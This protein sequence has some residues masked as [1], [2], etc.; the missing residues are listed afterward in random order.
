M[1]MPAPTSDASPS[2][3]I[4][5]SDSDSR[6]TFG[7]RNCFQRELRRRVEEF[8][9]DAGRPQR[10]CPQLY[11]KSALIL[12]AFAVSYG[13]LVFLAT[14]WWQAIPFALLLG[15]STTAIGFNIQHDAGHQAYSSRPWVNKL[16]SMTLDLIGGSSYVW[17][18]KH[19][20]YHHTYVNITGHDTDIDLGIVG[21]L[22]PHQKRH[23]FHRWQ[24][25]YLWPAYGLLA[26]KWHFFTD[27]H[28]VVTGRIGRHRMP[29]PKGWDLA[30]FLGGK[31]TF[32]G[33]AFVI[34]LLFHP[35][36]IVLLVY[37]L[38]VVILGAV[39]SVV[40]QLAH[41]VEEA[42]FPIPQPETGNIENAWA[43]HQV[44]TTIDFVRRNR[45]VAWLLG[46]LNFQIEHHLFPRIC[47]INYPEISELVEATCREY[48]V[49]YTE[50]SSFGAGLRSHFRWLR[51]MGQPEGRD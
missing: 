32:F 38:V 24:H 30:L 20:V 13:C 44:E 6:V 9:Q 36:E 2:D 47:H 14:T 7:K 33:I 10:D 49:R 41:A 1:S 31:T 25:L 29:R 46:G 15:L 21:R 39:L 3:A 42:D 48:G 18:W 40:F 37:A 43:V 34:P 12:I 26:V 11:L 22:T 35:V 19:A 5:V 28:E 50:H 23:W 8:L 4:L 51:C 17:H 16:M 27:F 45:F